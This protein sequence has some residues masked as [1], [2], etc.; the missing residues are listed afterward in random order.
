MLAAERQARIAHQIS[1]QRSVTVSELSKQF[2]VS[3]M[4]IR[5]DLHAWR[6]A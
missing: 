2:S 1:R 5:R 4:T 3:D 6:P